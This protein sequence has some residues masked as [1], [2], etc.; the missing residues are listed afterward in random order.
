MYAIDSNNTETQLCSYSFSENASDAEFRP[1]LNE[2]NQDY[3]YYLNRNLSSTENANLTTGEYQIK[4]TVAIGGN[5]GGTV[6]IDYASFYQQGGYLYA[7]TNLGLSTP[8]IQFLEGTG[9]ISGQLNTPLTYYSNGTNEYLYFGTYTGSR[10]YYEYN[11]TTETL[12]AFTPY[13]P[14]STTKI[15]NFYW[16][17]AAVVTVGSTDY[18][19]FGSD[20][21]TDSGVKHTYLYYRKVGAFDSTTYGGY[22]DLNTLGVT[23]AGNVRS[24]ISKDS[25][26]LY[27][28]SQGPSAESYVWRVPIAS[29]GGTLTSSNV[30]VITLSGASSTSTPAISTNGFIYVGFYNGFS[31]GGVD[32]INQAN[33][34]KITDNNGQALIR[35]TGPVQASVIV[36]T[37]GNYNYLYFTTNS[38]SDYAYCYRH[39]VTNNSISLIWKFA[40]GDYALQGMAA[41]GGILTYGDDKDHFYI[42]K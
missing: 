9:S 3:Y 17:G 2:I 1:I 18:V 13:K 22:Y 14:N 25:N 8:S 16:A 26:Y 33:F 39:T 5:T 27:F 15:G 34:T 35:G 42:I 6:Q 38:N 10:S 32:V 29:I 21:F 23:E 19:V 4:Y 7:A 11:I 24:T 28:T 37:S 36:H 12:T 40:N 20:A 30:K 31:S 41:C